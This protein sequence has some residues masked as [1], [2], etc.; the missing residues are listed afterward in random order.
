MTP[1]SE[2]FESGRL[3]FESQQDT[4]DFISQGIEDGLGWL[5]VRGWSVAQQY[6]EGQLALKVRLKLSAGVESCEFDFSFLRI[7]P[8]STERARTRGDQSVD[9]EIHADEFRREIEQF[10]VFVLPGGSEDREQVIPSRV[11]LERFECG[12]QGGGDRLAVVLQDPLEIHGVLGEGEVIRI[13]AAQLDGRGIDGMVERVTEIVERVGC[14]YAQAP[15]EFVQEAKLRD[16]LAR[17]WV[18]FID[19]HRLMAREEGLGAS[20]EVIHVLPSALDE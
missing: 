8:E 19:G 16:M 4:F 17:L 15:R 6:A 12:D 7:P 13:P 5:R 9:C 18:A 11:W 2:G 14:R 20:I 10:P 3:R 1:K